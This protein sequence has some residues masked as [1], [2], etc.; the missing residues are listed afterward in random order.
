MSILCSTET[1]NSHKLL[2]CIGCTLFA[3][4]F[5]LFVPTYFIRRDGNDASHLTLPGIILTIF[6][7]LIIRYTYWQYKRNESHSNEPHDNHV[8]V[9]PPTM[10]ATTGIT[11]YN[12]HVYS[13]NENKVDLHADIETNLQPSLPTATY[14]DHKEDTKA[15]DMST[16]K[17]NSTS[18]QPSIFDQLN[19]NSAA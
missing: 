15:K 10:E 13:Q 14:S 11:G 16:P 7:V 5:G 8:N 19:S 4:G 2:F 1:K 17:H 6:G 9:P 12:N 3:S 18:M